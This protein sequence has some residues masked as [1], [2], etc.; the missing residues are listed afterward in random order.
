MAER[1]NIRVS[2]D[3][4]ELLVRLNEID[5][6]L[7][8]GPQGG[9]GKHVSMAETIKRALDTYAPVASNKLKTKP[10]RDALLTK[11]RAATKQ[12]KPERPV[13]RAYTRAELD[14]FDRKRKEQLA[15]YDADVA[16]KQKWSD[17]DVEY[18]KEQNRE[19]A[20]RRREAEK[21]ELFRLARIAQSNAEA[22]NKPK[23]LLGRLR[24]K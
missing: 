17:R 4:H 8:K 16:R 15:R 14:D 2:P 21:A 20:E 5:N 7:A 23:G 22:S 1:R 18:I 11:K 19:T 12:D 10:A 9:K 6:E 3:V 24:I 13:V